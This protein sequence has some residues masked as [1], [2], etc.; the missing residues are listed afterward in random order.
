MKHPRPQSLNRFVLSRTLLAFALLLVAV[1][2]AGYVLVTRPVLDKYAESL[3]ASLFPAGESCQIS[4]LQQRIDTLQ[5]QQ[6]LNGITVIQAHSPAF[7]TSHWSVVL[8]FDALLARHLSQQVG[9]PVIPASSPHTLQ[10]GFQCHGQTL[11]LQLD[12]ARAL[13][14]VP[15]LALLF[16]LSGLLGGALIMATMLSRALS[17]PLTRLAGH[18]RATPLGSAS[19]AAASIGIAELDELATEVDALRQRASNAVATRSALLMG[20]SH[21]LRAPLARLRL[22]L[23]TVSEPTQNDVSDLRHDVLELQDALDEFLRAANAMAS[24]SQEN[25]ASQAWLRLQRI[26]TSPRI[27]FEGT[28]DNSCPSLNTA[29]L[30]R[31]A[32]H[33]IDNALCHTDGQIAILWHSGHNWR[34]CV[35]DEGPGLSETA[36]LPFSSRNAHLSNHA[37]LGLTLASLICEHNGWQLSHGRGTEGRWQIGFSAMPS[38]RPVSLH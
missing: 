16:W 14:A 15:N 2:L 35:R 38:S 11:I 28:P 12:R 20:L 27:V 3:A 32:S 21:D 24:P 34:L 23:D 26:Y 9:S 4:N 1:G 7:S 22:I 25:G 13:G 10:L 36:F 31:V 30:V 29:A 5:H 19:P 37:G 8:P 17:R 33:L 6:G 18:L